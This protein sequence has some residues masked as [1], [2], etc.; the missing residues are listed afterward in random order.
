MIKKLSYILV[1]FHCLAFG[2]IAQHISSVSDRYMPTNNV[3]INPA[4]IA[5]PRPYI[6]FR[7][8]GLSVQAENNLYFAPN[9]S[10]TGDFR[11]TV[12]DGKKYNAA[13]NAD[14]YA[15][16]F[17]MTKG[18][19]SFGFNIRQR[20]MVYAKNIPSDIAGFIRNGLNYPE[21]HGPIYTGS[22][23]HL[24]YM[25]W[26][27]LGL[28]YAQLIY[29]KGDVMMS[30]GGSLKILNGLGHINL[31][32]EDFRYSVDSN[33]VYVGSANSRISLSLPGPTLGFGLG[34]DLG[35]EFKKMLSDD[36]SYHIPHSVSRKCA[37]KEYKYKIGLSIIDLGFL[38]HK[39][40]S[41]LW[42][43]EGDSLFWNNYESNNISGI[44][45]M[46]TVLGNSASNAGSTVSSKEK[47]VAFMPL[48][49]NAQFD[50]NLDYNFY[51]YSAL[52]LGIHQRLM[53]GTER[54]TRLSLVPR[55]ERERI[56][57]ALPV[58]FSRHQSPGLGFYL[59]AYFLSVGTNNFV[60]LLR[61]TD[62]YGADV[63][64]SLNWQILHSNDCETYFKKRKNYCPKPERRLFKKKKKKPRELNLEWK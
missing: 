18:N 55:Y 25:S 58:T 7:L 60:P 59:R 63:Y 23:Y 52:E 39:K 54:V 2:G 43:F 29:K 46:N 4:S 57:A 32:S 62:M 22:N 38:N 10:L 5:D 3:L 9:A 61:K 21:Q 15:P 53:L 24:K 13:V 34:A 44:T 41:T 36:N 48:S 14:I 33:H 42:T 19:Y 56:T 31:L 17:V 20:N 6:D 11:A 27:E 64:V 45:R 37:I 49:I 40:N 35:I 51:F 26:A 30:G 50:Y 16:A 8:F 12:E 28:N 1:I 47:F